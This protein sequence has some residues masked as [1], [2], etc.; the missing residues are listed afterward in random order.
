MSP[1]SLPTF[2]IQVLTNG[3][4]FQHL[5]FYSHLL[6]SFSGQIEMAVLEHYEAMGLVETWGF[7]FS[8]H[9]VYK[10]DADDPEACQVRRGFMV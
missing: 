10:E 7:R 9:L 4:S 2:M 3:I 8:R 1:R 5:C 6:V